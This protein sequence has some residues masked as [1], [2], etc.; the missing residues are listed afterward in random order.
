MPKVKKVRRPRGAAPSPASA[1]QNSHGRTL[2]T[3]NTG[4]GQHFLKNP[5]IA[6]QIVAK[7][8]IRSTDVCLEV[9]PGTGNLTMKLLEAAK[10]VVAVEFDPRMISEVT[11]RVQ[12]TEHAKHL[13]II[14]GD[15]IKVQLPFFDVCVANLPYQISSPFVFKLLAHRPMFRCAV[16][17]FQE[18]FAIRLSAKPGDSL[19][20]RLS[21]N[22]QL[23]AKVDQLM[24]VGRNNFR[25]PPKVESRVVRIEP[26]NPPPPVNFQ[27]WDGMIKII[28]NRKNKTL[29]AS[30]NTKCVFKMMEDNYRTFCSIA[31]EPMAADFSI[32]TLVDEVLDVTG[33][34]QTRGAKMDQDDF[35]TLLEAFNSRGIHFA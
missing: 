10:K 13:Q 2:A 26:R 31:N 18:E 12:A 19:Y 9:G 8:A 28:F 21:V 15:V 16:V 4:L 3:P 20:C 27:E 23:L 22:V 17:M 29:R 32:K 25:P 1:S 34:S 24:K 11:K 7:A 5:M 30:F 6:T 33:F 35:L 14:H